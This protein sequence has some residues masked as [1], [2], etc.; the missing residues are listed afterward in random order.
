MTAMG[1][2]LAGGV[3]VAAL[4][5]ARARLRR[6]G[7][8]GKWKPGWGSAQRRLRAVERLALGPQHALHLV[9]CQGRRLLLSVSPAGCRLL[10]EWP[11][12]A[13]AATGETAT[14]EISP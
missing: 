14:G 3:L 10:A 6:H 2:T 9:D 13:D 11:P 12:E 1:Q 5:A 7:L 8:G 4:G